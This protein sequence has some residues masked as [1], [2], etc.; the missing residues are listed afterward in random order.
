MVWRYTN[1]TLLSSS[2]AIK[3]S[4]GSTLRKEIG[5]CFSS[6]TRR[7]FHDFRFRRSR[8]LFIFRMSNKDIIV[9]W[10]HGN[11][12]VCKSWV[13]LN[14]PI[15]RSKGLIDGTRNLRQGP[16]HLCRERIS[17]H[18]NSQWFTAWFVSLTFSIDT[19][20]TR[21]YVCHQRAFGYRTLGTGRTRAQSRASS[22]DT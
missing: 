5:T 8:R 21:W 15:E 19:R 13:P 4:H 9:V 2:W 20:T 12:F 22:T 16:G 17:F 6:L 7:R 3:T 18:V 14:V 1:M 10:C 11:T